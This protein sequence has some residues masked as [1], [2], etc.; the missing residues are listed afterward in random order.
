MTQVTRIYGT[1]ELG[2]MLYLTEELTS[3]SFIVFRL[4]PSNLSTFNLP[5]NNNP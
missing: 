1:A 5:I 4:E 3:R 2:Q